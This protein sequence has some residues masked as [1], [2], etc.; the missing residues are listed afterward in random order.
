MLATEPLVSP[1]LA[2]FALLMSLVGFPTLLAFLVH[3]IG[4]RSVRSNAFIGWLRLGALVYVRYFQRARIEGTERIPKTV[5]PEGLIVV[6]TH[7]A[8]LDPVILQTIMHHWIRWMMSAEMMLPL[9]GPL[10]RRQRV[11]PVCFDARDAAALKAAIAHVAAGGVLGIFPEG[12]IARPPRHLRPFPGGLR[13]ILSR[14]KAPVVVCAIDPGKVCETAYAALLT[15]TRPVV[16]VL[17]VIEPGA[18]GHSKDTSDRIFALLRE[19]TGWPINE[20]PPEEANKATVDRNLRAY[21]GT[22]D[23]D[24]A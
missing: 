13:L 19:A 5:G 12:A 21:L 10:W 18:T 14:T 7:G 15:P 17:A 24:E 16:R 6:S 1:A 4:D 11:I 20:A 9:L 2:A 8:G 3:R 23:A 22:D